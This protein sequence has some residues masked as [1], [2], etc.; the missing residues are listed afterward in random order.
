MKQARAW[1]RM[2]S[3]RRLDL[4][5]PTPV[6]IEIEDIAHGL[7]F[8][9][10]W[11]GQ[12]RGDYPYS[13][14]EHSLL[15]EEIFCRIQPEA[16]VRWRLAALLHDAPEY[17]IGDMISP[18]KAAVGPSYGELD[19]RLA[20]AIHIRFGLP[21]AVP[22]TVKARIKRADSLSAWLEATQIA[23]F[24]PAEAN[25]FFGRPRPDLIEGLE[26]RLRPPV[27]V[28]TAYTARHAALM[29]RL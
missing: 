1:Q 27:E 29:A 20:S 28:R 17:V 23:G 25:R 15:V 9:A 11:N 16:P 21:A 26:I 5:D 22:K 2:L 12:T 10:R 19:K 4:L 24:A 18:V 7:A 6:D 13:V 14:A 8:V 3:G